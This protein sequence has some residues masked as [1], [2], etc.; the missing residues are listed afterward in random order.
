[1]KKQVLLV[2]YTRALG[3]AEVLEKSDN[4]FTIGLEREVP[5]DS[6]VVSVKAGMGVRRSTCGLC[7]RAGTERCG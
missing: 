7:L 3:T 5:S 4:G 6:A 2:R 1:M